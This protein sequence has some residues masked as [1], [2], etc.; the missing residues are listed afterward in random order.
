MKELCSG[1]HDSVLRDT[2]EAVKCFHWET[3][4]L[5]FENK[6]PTLMTV[7]KQIVPLAAEHRPLLGLLIFSTC[8]G[9]ISD[10]GF[11]AE[12]Y[13]SHAVWKQLV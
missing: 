8:Q 9:Q 3:V 6:L 10:D 1:E 4:M 7:L 13:F 2:T 11:S 12:S 5:E